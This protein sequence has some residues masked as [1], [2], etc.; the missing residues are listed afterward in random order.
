M[1]P[2]GYRRHFVGLSRSYPSSTVVST[3][4]WR[5]TPQVGGSA[6]NTEPIGSES[7]RYIA[8]S[9]LLAFANDCHYAKLFRFD[10]ACPHM[11]NWFCESALILNVAQT[12]YYLR[13]S[14]YIFIRGRYRRLLNSCLCYCFR[15]FSWT[16]IRTRT[17]GRMADANSC[18]TLSTRVQESSGIRG[19]LYR[20]I[21]LV[22][23]T[24]RY[25]IFLSV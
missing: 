12:D 15:C 3:P 1:N 25:F 19:I 9:T 21:P 6:Y 8:E 17:W 11:R 13:T 14:H 24:F 23:I 20:R 22:D 16:W 4:I 7:S 2:F 10:E 18:S 5:Y